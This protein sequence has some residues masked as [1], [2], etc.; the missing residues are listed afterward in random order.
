MHEPAP[1][2]T[3]NILPSQKIESTKLSHLSPEERIELLTLIDKFSDCF[4]ESPGFCSLV[5][6]VIPLQSN[7]VP[8]RLTSYR[9]PLKLR[10]QVEQQLEE[11]LKLGIFRHSKS[12]MTSPVICLLKGKDGKG[13]VRLAI[14]Y[15]YVNKFTISDPYPVPDL[16]DIVQQVGN[17]RYISTFDAT[18]GY[19]QTPVREQDR[20]LTAF[21]CEFGVF[22]FTITPFGM[23]S[24]GAT[25]V[26]T[27]QRVLQPVRKFTASY[28]DDMSVYSDALEQHCRIWKNS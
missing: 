18:K 12:L 7:F 6:R 24:S 8:K 28:V 2:R 17:A 14:G 26:R 10:A 1:P 22:E 3:N 11:L 16:A 27:V 15:R 25:F 4:S 9:I 13:G 5:E 20:W 19:Y 23:R 21:V